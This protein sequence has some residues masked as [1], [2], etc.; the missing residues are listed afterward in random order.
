VTHSTLH[1]SRHVF[2]VKRERLCNRA[3]TTLHES[4]CGALLEPQLSHLSKTESFYFLALQTTSS[5]F[6]SYLKQCSNMLVLHTCKKCMYISYD[7]NRKEGKHELSS[8]SCRRYSAW[9]EVSVYGKNIP[10]VVVYSQEGKFYALYK[11]RPYQC[12]DLNYGVLVG[13]TDII[14]LG[15]EF[16]Y[17]REGEILRCLWHSFSCDVITG[18]CLTAL[19]RLRVKTY[20]VIVREQEV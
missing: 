16:E 17:G 12:G 5:L 10:V 7:L 20:S 1:E 4:M 14:Q 18:I 11:T 9:R 3:T 19:E 2:A 6:S 13:P 15:K 8:A